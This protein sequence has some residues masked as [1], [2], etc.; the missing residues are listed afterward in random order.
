[1]IIAQLEA[2]EEPDRGDEGPWAQRPRQ[3]P[4]FEFKITKHETSEARRC[5]CTQCFH[6]V[7]AASGRACALDDLLKHD[8][9]CQCGRHVV[10]MLSVGIVFIHEDAYGVSVTYPTKC[11]VQLP[12]CKRS[13]RLV[14]RM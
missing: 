8:V 1:M 11:D 10:R 5:L 7:L 14:F 13:V 6:C 9:C 2:R 12:V 4:R 3:R